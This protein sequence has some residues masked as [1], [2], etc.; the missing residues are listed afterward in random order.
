MSECVDDFYFMSESEIGFYSGL[1]KD[2]EESRKDELVQID[3]VLR[4]WAERSNEEYYQGELEKHLPT[5]LRLSRQCPFNDVRNTFETFL[6]DLVQ[7][8]HESIRPV[9]T[10]PSRFLK[11]FVPIDT[12]ERN[13]H[14]L[15]KDMFMHD[16]KVTHMVQTLMHCPQ[17]L[18]V[19]INTI[20][21][22]MRSD[23]P[24]PQDW[25][26]YIAILAVSRHDCAY[27]IHVLSSQFLAYGG[28]PLWLQDI[29]Y[30]PIRI[31]KLQS[32]NCVQAHMPWS[33]TSSHIEELVK[34]ADNW[35]MSEL[36][37]IAVIFAHYHCLCGVVYGLGLNPEL[38]APGGYTFAPSMSYSVSAVPAPTPSASVSPEDVSQEVWAPRTAE[39]LGES[40]RNCGNNDIGKGSDEDDNDLD[41]E[42]EKEGE[43]RRMDEFENAETLYD[44]MNHDDPDRFSIYT[45][46]SSGWP[47]A[48]VDFNQKNNPPLRIQ[49]YSWQDQA[50][51][52]LNRY[53]GGVAQLLDDEFKVAIEMTDNHLGQSKVDTTRFRHAIWFYIHRTCGILH[54]DYDYSEVNRLVEMPLKS[55][56]KRVTCYPKTTKYQDFLGCRAGLRDPETAHIT[57]LAMEARK[58]AELLFFLRALAEY[59]NR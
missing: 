49:D 27:L 4:E 17:F 21:Y 10:G 44:E 56:I 24:L 5:V 42:E 14:E 36:T 25:R 43:A 50:F 46:V 9:F 52:T 59:M 18:S 54:D 7:A 47:N 6:H 8:G 11:E 45:R 32:L 22:V 19:F 2:H 53:L 37:Q 38:D 1:R 34:G 58:Q 41:V 12:K 40:G 31:Q 23:G 35:S 20:H 16:G 30:A 29:S 13:Q 48:H 26:H 55:Y 15:F 28:D 33:V 3:G 57:I 39:L 51:S